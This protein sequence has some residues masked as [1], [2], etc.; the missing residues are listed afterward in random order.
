MHPQ[1]EIRGMCVALGAL[2]GLMGVVVQ[3]GSV[4]PYS[5]SN[6]YRCASMRKG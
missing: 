2:A 1:A 4:A 5:D 3:G 6:D